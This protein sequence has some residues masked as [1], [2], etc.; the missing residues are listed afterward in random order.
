MPFV[1]VCSV[2]CWCISLLFCSILVSFCF[3]LFAFL[4][5]H[6]FLFLLVSLHFDSFCM[7]SLGF[8]FFALDSFRFLGF[9]SFL[10][11]LCHLVFS[12]RYICYALGHYDFFLVR[13]VDLCDIWCSFGSF[14]LLSFAFAS[15]CFLLFTLVLFCYIFFISLWF[16]WCPFISSC[17]MWCPFASCCFISF[18]VLFRFLSFPSVSFGSFLWSTSD[19][20]GMPCI[21]YLLS[22]YAYTLHR[23]IQ[24]RCKLCADRGIQLYM[25]VLEQI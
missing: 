10:S 3:P 4:F 2:S 9:H 15:F 24:K 20:F 25:L 21:C 19:S 5:F 8:Y 23:E 6:C 12:F 1:C 18:F 17:L 13:F 16:L 14:C 11:L 7:D 22:A